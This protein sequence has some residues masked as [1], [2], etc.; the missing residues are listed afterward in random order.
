MTPVVMKVK[1]ENNPL[2]GL[3]RIPRDHTNTLKSKLV[4]VRTSNLDTAR[5]SLSL[6]SNIC[7]VVSRSVASDA[8]KAVDD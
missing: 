1:E 8:T 4:S 3:M 6:C 5:T 2:E 7:A